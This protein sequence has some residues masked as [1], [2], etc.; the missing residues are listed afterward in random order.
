MM[1]LIPTS[2]VKIDAAYPDKDVRHIYE[3]L[4]HTLSLPSQFPI[5]AIK[6]IR[7]GES[8]VVV[9]GH[10]YLKISRDLGRDRIRAIL[11]GV[12]ANH[13]LPAGAEVVPR[14]VLEREVSLPVVRDFHVY[15]F[16]KPLGEYEKNQFSSK[17]AGFFL[18]LGSP[19]LSKKNRKIYSISFPFD[20]VCA[21]FEANIPV[22][23]RSW[24]EDY[25]R[26]TRVFSRDVARI[27][28]FQG[29]HFPN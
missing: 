6:I 26:V 25:L 21:Q 14:S 16:S 15:F 18:S 2:S 12:G 19:L 3:H 8:F 20:G 1:L 13:M 27:V 28:S 22:G 29:A 24:L 17:V 4:R 23:D 9:D 5:P 7:S 11:N 10:K